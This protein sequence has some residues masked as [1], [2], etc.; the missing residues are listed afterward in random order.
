MRDGAKRLFDIFWAGSGLLMLLPWL[1]VVAVVIRLGDGGPAFFGQERV[2]RKGKV[3]R[4]W[5]FRTMVV[6]AERWGSQLTQVGD[7]RV[8]RIGYWLR[9]FKLDELPQL[10]NVLMGEMSLV[11]P[12]PEVPRH[13]DWDAPAWYIVL[14]VRPGITDLATLLYRHEEELL[15]ASTDPDRYY[16]ETVLP[17]KLNLSVQYMRNSSFWSDLK[18]ILLTARYSFFPTGFRR[19]YVEQVFLPQCEHRTQTLGAEKDTG[20]PEEETA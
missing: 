3:F 11:G 5:K 6:D 1:L 7:H 13:V 9:R 16:R 2:G 15:A 19:S 20:T 4:V 12:R 18:V 14:Q 10:F 8:T 17:S